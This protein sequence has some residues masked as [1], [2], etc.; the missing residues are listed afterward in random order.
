MARSPSTRLA[1]AFDVEVHPFQKHPRTQGHARSSSKA[2]LSTKKLNSILKNGNSEKKHSSEE[3]S[4]DEGGSEDE[5]DG[6]HDEGDL[7]E[8]DDEDPDQIAPSRG[9]GRGVGKH[10]AIRVDANGSDAL[11]EDLDGH[12]RGAGQLT[13]SPPLLGLFDSP[14]KKRTFSHLGSRSLANTDGSSSDDNSALRSSRR[15][16]KMPRAS[17]SSRRGIL[18]NSDSRANMAQTNGTNQ[19]PELAIEET[20]DDDFYKAVDLISDSEDEN[21]LEKLEEAMIIESEDGGLTRRQPKCPRT[22]GFVGTDDGLTSD[23]LFGDVGSFDE[24]FNR[25]HSADGSPADRDTRPRRDSDKRVRFDDDVAVSETIGSSTSSEVDSDVFPDLFG[26]P[27]SSVYQ[28][29]FDT[30]D[31]DHFGNSSNSDS[32]RSFWDF[33]GDAWH[34]DLHQVHTETESPEGSSSGYETDEG[35]T[36]DEEPTQPLTIISKPSSVLR[37]RSSAAGEESCPMPQTLRKPARASKAPKGPVLGEFIINPKKSFVLIDKSATRIVRY[38]PMTPRRSSSQMWDDTT[39]QNSPAS[40]FLAGDE[41]DSSHMSNAAF[42]VDVMLGSFF[43]GSRPAGGDFV[44]GQAIGPPEAFFPFYNFNSDGSFVPEDEVMVEDDTEGETLDLDDFLNLGDATTTSAADADSADVDDADD[45]DVRVTPATSMLAQ[46]SST[47]CYS[48]DNSVADNEI[49]HNLLDH[50]DRTPIGAFRANQD[51]SR[52]LAGLHQHPA[53]R[54]SASRPLRVGRDAD[55]LITPLRRRK[56]S[57][58]GVGKPQGSPLRP[59]YGKGNVNMG[60]HMRRMG[61]GSG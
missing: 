48:V 37:R 57:R 12:D 31:V 58:S 14:S 35:D 49:T 26:T 46:P 18:T 47:P 1:K 34:H 27:K 53:V 20:T 54:A 23:L 43:A 33:Q 36:T 45:T 60:P 30:Q 9:A 10:P 28:L 44:L 8:D 16:K 39:A 4:A 15:P 19:V 6:E 38:P 51:R 56:G 40:L 32:E 52:G 13:S 11:V 22:A 2:Q 50:F 24:H 3:D 42:G 61:R 25:G 5:G 7:E 21:D 41:S 17:S 55:A 29:V 59:K